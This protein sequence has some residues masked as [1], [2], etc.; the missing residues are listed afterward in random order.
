MRILIALL[1]CALALTSQVGAVV[2]PSKCVASI[3]ASFKPGTTGTFM[4]L[5]LRDL[6]CAAGCVPP[7]T[8]KCWG[9]G[10][11]TTS[12]GIVLPSGRMSTTC[13]NQTQVGA[14]GTTSL[15]FQFRCSDCAGTQPPWDAPSW[16]ID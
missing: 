9:S 2:A 1:A 15:V 12:A 6:D 5:G 7:T 16:P 8:G 4:V 3:K 11:V 14:A 13:N 10:Q